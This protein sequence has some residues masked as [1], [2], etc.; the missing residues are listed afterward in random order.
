MKITNLGAHF[1]LQSL[2]NTSV[3]YNHHGKATIQ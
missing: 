2:P 1:E 3:V